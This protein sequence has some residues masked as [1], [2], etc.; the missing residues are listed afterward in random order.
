MPKISAYFGNSTIIP[1]DSAVIKQA[2]RCPFTDVVFATEKEYLSHLKRT[3]NTIHENIQHK[4]RGKIL[5]DLWRQPTFTDI[6]A[7][8]ESHQKFIYHNAMANI[9]WRSNKK[10]K[11]SSSFKFR[12]SYLNLR[13]SESCS[14]SH[15]APHDGY[16]NW[17]GDR[18]LAR[19][20]PGW[21]GRIEF[22]VDSKIDISASDIVANLR[23]HTGTGGSTDSRNYGYAVT[24]FDSDWPMLAKQYSEKK[25]FNILSERENDTEF[26]YGETDYFKF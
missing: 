17:G 13:R 6:I 4:N 3:R 26:Q 2:Y 23:I 11:D 21:T 10:A 22:E 5:Q 24:F 12:I 25:V 9:A 8:I 16:T 14:N 19:G 18:K 15:A 7:W 1:V 20:Y